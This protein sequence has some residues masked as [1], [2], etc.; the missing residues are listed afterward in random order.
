MTCI[1]IGAGA[2]GFFS[3]IQHK[4]THPK[5]EVIIIEKSKEVLAKVKISGGGRC[6]VTHA[7]FEPRDLIANY[8]RGAKALLGPFHQF[9]PRDTVDWFQ[10]RGVPLKTEADGR[11]FPVSDSSQSIVD[12]LMKEAEKLGV[13]L[14]TE[15]AVKK[16]EKDSDGRFT[17]E[18]ANGQ[19]HGCEKVILATGS[20]RSGY[21]FARSLG[22]TIVDPVPSLFTFA[23]KDS[24]L[25]ALSG[26][27]VAKATAWIH[28]K[29]PQTGPL[30]I[31][32]WGLSGPAI[33][34]LSAWHAR[35]LFEQKYQMPVTI[36]CLADWSLS[37]LEQRV[38]ECRQAQPKK[39]ISQKSPFT[40]IPGRLWAYFLGRSGIS[41]SQ[42]WHDLS[43]KQVARLL[44]ELRQGRFEISG[45]G[46]FKE[47][48][49]T[50]GGVAL[51][52]IDFK[53]MESKVCN[54]LH[55]VG[56]LLDIDG[57]TGG[58]NFQNAWTTGFL[59]GVA[60]V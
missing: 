5:D 42:I 35:D 40:E 37:D 28:K 30:L 14:W 38:Q 7:C 2:A 41:P 44:G 9:Q 47:E 17:L 56:E 12:C 48:F 21:D 1:I 20:S 46:V 6:N 16:I 58:F 57:V 15:C 60:N 55:I 27:S 26:L 53:A 59:A 52:E 43:A 4:S 13:K 29:Q 54:G 34:K 11:M 45:K 31:T 39:Q 19:S 24:D 23:I 33:I 22:H 49:V 50:C 10:S 32:H 25:H 36:N 8:P 51:D 18:L 3:A